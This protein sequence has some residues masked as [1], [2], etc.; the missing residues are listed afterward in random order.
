MGFSAAP[1]CTGF[2]TFRFDAFCRPRS[3]LYR[4]APLKTRGGSRRSALP[5]R[6]RTP[7]PAVH[8][9]GSDDA[10]LQSENL[11]AACAGRQWRR[12]APNTSAEDFCRSKIPRTGSSRITHA[13]NSRS[14]DAFAECV[15]RQWGPPRRDRTRR[16]QMPAP[17]LHDALAS[18]LPI[19]GTEMRHTT[20][21]MGAC[22]CGIACPCKSACGVGVRPTPGSWRSAP[23]ATRCR[24]GRT[25]SR[26]SSARPTARCVAACARTVP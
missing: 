25:R 12:P 7:R 14:A 11:H 6:G 4:T 5:A 17:P 3:W 26:A 20:C 18:P 1:R 16:H 22:R 9:Q 21:Y 19:A 13:G 10:R 2:R 15:H 8:A 23:G 24:R